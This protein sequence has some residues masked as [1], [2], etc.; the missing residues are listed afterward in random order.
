MA[1]MITLADP[2]MALATGLAGLRSWLAIWAWDK[3]ARICG[4]YCAPARM[5]RLPMS[6]NGTAPDWSALLTQGARRSSTIT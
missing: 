3:P 2:S 4:L 6:R 5:Q 1:A